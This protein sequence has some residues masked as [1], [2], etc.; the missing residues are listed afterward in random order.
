MIV[1]CCDES[2]DDRIGHPS[3]P[4]EMCVDGAWVTPQPIVVLRQATEAEY[5]QG[6][7]DSGATPQEV[8][9]DRRVRNAGGPWFYYLVSTD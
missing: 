4:S 2:C 3:T 6:M 9:H 1:M 5:E 8:E 7:I